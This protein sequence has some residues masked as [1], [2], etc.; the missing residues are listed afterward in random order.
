MPIGESMKYLR[1]LDTLG[2]YSGIYTRG[3]GGGGREGQYL[4]LPLC[5][6]AHSP[7]VKGVY[8]KREEIA[9]FGKNWVDF[10]QLCAREAIF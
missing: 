1:G 9:P 6:L 4:C 5:F 10:L 8:S 3:R 2:K 7:S